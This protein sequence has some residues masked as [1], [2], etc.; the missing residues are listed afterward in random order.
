MN[1]FMAWQLFGL[2]G[3]MVIPAT[4]FIKIDKMT[5]NLAGAGDYAGRLPVFVPTEP[6]PEWE[7]TSK[8]G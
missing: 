4:G 2:N 1:N 6:M 7:S 8:S 5:I 3:M